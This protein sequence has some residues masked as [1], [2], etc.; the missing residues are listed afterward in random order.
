MT[1]G[2]GNQTRYIRTEGGDIAAVIDP[3]V[4]VTR[5]RYDKAHRLMNIVQGAGTEAVTSFV[6]LSIQILII[7]EKTLQKGKLWKRRYFGSQNLK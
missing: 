1:D 2:L 6:A 3:L 5:Y 4:N 7:P